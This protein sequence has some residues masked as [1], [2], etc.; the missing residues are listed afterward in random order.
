MVPEQ[1]HRATVAMH[2]LEEIIASEGQHMLLSG[3]IVVPALVAWLAPG[4]W[5]LI[6]LLCFVVA[7]LFDYFSERLMRRRIARTKNPSPQQLRRL[8]QSLMLQGSL[9]V[10][11]YVLPNL[12]LAFAPGYGPWLGFCLSLMAGLRQL[13]SQKSTR[14]MTALNCPVVSAG[15]I[16]NALAIGGWVGAAL[17]VIGILVN[18]WAHAR[19][20]SITLGE[21]ID[22]QCD[23]ADAARVLEQRVHE[24][25]FELREA[26]LAAEAANQAKSTFLTK[27]SHELR[28]PLNAIFG[29][30]EIIEEDLAFGDAAAC[31]AHLARVRH[32][33]K[34]LLTL[35]DDV[36]DLSNIEADTLALYD[37]TI[38]CRALGREAM[39]MIASAAAAN[40]TQC[41]LIVSPGA[42]TLCA[43]RRRLKQCLVHLLS[44][45]AKFTE[46]GRIIL[47]IHTSE[48]YG[49]PAIAFEV[50]DTGGGIAKDVQGRLFQPFVQADDTISRRH[51]GAGLGLSITRLL[52]RLMGGDVTLES[53][54]GAGA[55]FT[56]LTPRQRMSESV[57][58]TLDAAAA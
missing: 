34:H 24:R 53:E 39:D 26:M 7:G 50:G 51:D 58:I 11:L 45:A 10:G 21:L 12:L 33:S 49:A 3:F 17:A 8:T 23:I 20:D 56:L 1:H 37:E 47:H 31:P 5:W 29:Y 13:T 16:V 35:I 55:R 44:N 27:M 4:P 43:D 18:T 2:R 40:K 6:S 22:R 14:A 25:T 30:T 36:L 54:L 42:E 41:E 52:A 46:G 9:S 48:F 28:T 15:L 38:D 57:A 19:S 32:A